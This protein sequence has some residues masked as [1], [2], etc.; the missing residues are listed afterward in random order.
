MNHI[1]T[2][3]LAACLVLLIAS[4]A[5]SN[6]L[7]EY[8][9]STDNFL[10]AAYVSSSNTTGWNDG[11]LYTGD[12]LSTRYHIFIAI[13]DTL[14]F[15]N[16]F[17]HCTLDSAKLSLVVVGKTGSPGALN[18]HFIKRDSTGAGIYPAYDDSRSHYCR[19][20][21]RSRRGAL[22][23]ACPDSI[24][25][26]TPGATGTN[27]Y[28][29]VPFASIPDPQPGTRYDVDITP[30]I[31]GI[32]DETDTVSNG[33]LVVIANE[34]GSGTDYIGFRSIWPFYT[35]DDRMILKLWVSNW[36]WIKVR[37]DSNRVEDG[38]F[39]IDN[40]DTIFTDNGYIKVGTGTIP[41]DPAHVGVIFPD[42]S[43]LFGDDA[44]P[45]GSAVDSARLYLYADQVSNDFIQAGEILPAATFVNGQFPTW[46]TVAPGIDWSSGSWT[47]DDVVERG[48]DYVN[49]PDAWYDWPVGEMI[50]R[51][52]DSTATRHGLAL[53][54]SGPF[55]NK[56]TTFIDRTELGYG[57]RAGSLLVWFTPPQPHT[58]RRA[59]IDTPESLK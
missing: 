8:C 58:T 34:D 54:E 48:S 33:I 14:K 2:L 29:P 47:P 9:D 49:I 50:Q 43:T 3:S 12:L 20:E 23:Y 6:R 42:D 46:D 7:L 51:W 52:L 39:T 15:Q 56:A 4:E 55:S 45:E 22:S 26:E 31:A 36:D 59:W 37:L 32:I 53:W 10:A 5:H 18:F 44:I 41:G 19:S 16:L 11:T 25:W 38:W 40:P 17:E 57:S 28:N 35:G 24:L 1:R 27:D 13:H 21:W 30:W